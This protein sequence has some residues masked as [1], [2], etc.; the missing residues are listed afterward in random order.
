MVPFWGELSKTDLWRNCKIWRKRPH[1]GKSETCATGG[2]D[3]CTE[4]C[5]EGEFEE[6]RAVWWKMRAGHFV[7]K[8]VVS[9]SFSDLNPWLFWRTNLVLSACLCVCNSSKIQ[10]Y[11]WTFLENATQRQAYLDANFFIEILE[12]HK[13][14]KVHEKGVLWKAPLE[15]SQAFFF[16]FF[17]LV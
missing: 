11:F 6:E 13:C 7:H 8:P 1:C 17:A 3:S 15:N 2:V 4:V 14:S 9:W 10:M 12:Y 5:A 16:F